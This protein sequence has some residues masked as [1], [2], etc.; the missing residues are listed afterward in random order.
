MRR[1][2]VAF[3]FIILFYYN[4]LHGHFTVQQK[5]HQITLRKVSLKKILGYCALEKNSLHGPTQRI[6]GPTLH[7]VNAIFF[8][9]FDEC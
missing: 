1:V 3:P 7:L 8:N 9:T 5:L 6:L 4:K 2:C